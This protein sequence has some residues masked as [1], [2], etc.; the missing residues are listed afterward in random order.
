MGHAG[1]QNAAHKEGFFIFLLVIH[2]TRS[3]AELGPHWLLRRPLPFFARCLRSYFEAPARSNEA[4]C[5]VSP[6][7]KSCHS[8]WINCGS[9]SKVMV[10]PRGKPYPH[11][12]IFTQQTER[13]ALTYPGCLRKP[14]VKK[15]RTRSPSPYRAFAK[16]HGSRK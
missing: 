11:R 12:T 8:T 10:R 7:R 3:R 4:H 9:T 2:R 16:P 6:Q 5:A 1:C 13:R 15:A 14:D